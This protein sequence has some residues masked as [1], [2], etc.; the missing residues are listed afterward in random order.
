[1][2]EFET[3]V[4]GTEPMI[5]HHWSSEEGRVVDR[6]AALD[7]LSRKDDTGPP[8]TIGQHR[9]CFTVNVGDTS[10]RRG[11]AQMGFPEHTETILV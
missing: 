5:L 8:S 6:G 10:E 7:D 11:G 2:G 9:N 1:M 4:S 3:R